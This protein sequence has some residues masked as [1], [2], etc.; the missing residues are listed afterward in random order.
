MYFPQASF[1][2]TISNKDIFPLDVQI[3]Y[4]HVCP[5]ANPVAGK[6]WEKRAGEWGALLPSG[7]VRLRLWDDS[8]YV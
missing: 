7:P 3:P 2:E 8:S 1:P 6:M 4:W 5:S